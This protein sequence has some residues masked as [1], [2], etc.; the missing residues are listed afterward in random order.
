MEPEGSLE[1]LQLSAIC[2]YPEMDESSPISLQSTFLLP[3]S[4]RCP[5][6][7]TH[8]DLI[9]LIMSGDKHKSYMPQF[10]PSFCHFFHL[11]TSIFLGTTCLHEASEYE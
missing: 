8:L 4:A 9:T 10:S 1:H 7:L 5:S 6:H 3:I 2:H 11:V